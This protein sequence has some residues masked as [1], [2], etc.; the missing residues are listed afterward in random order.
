M[1]YITYNWEQGYVNQF[2]HSCGPVKYTQVAFFRHSM[3]R[4]EQLPLAPLF[5]FLCIIH[6]L[7]VLWQSLNRHGPK[8]LEGHWFDSLKPMLIL[9][10]LWCTL[11]FNCWSCTPRSKGTLRVHFCNSGYKKTLPNMYSEVMD[12]YSHSLYETDIHSHQSSIPPVVDLL[13]EKM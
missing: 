9:S 1:S 2:S 4:W 6:R 5:H 8:N 3:G 7:I 11:V 12:I 10:H 13:D